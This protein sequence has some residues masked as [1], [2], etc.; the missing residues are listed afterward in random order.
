MKQRISHIV[1]VI[2]ALAIGLVPQVASAGNSSPVY[3]DFNKS[4]V[5]PAGVWQ[6]TVSGDIEG[7]LTT[8]LTDLRVTGPIWHVEFDWI[9]DSEDDN[10]DFTAHLTGVLNTETGG[11]V[12]NGNVV[13]G[14]LLGAQVHEAG[15]LVDPVTLSFEGSIR[16]MPATAP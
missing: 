13:D 6:G 14:Y 9:I 16:I 15:Q 11:V 5:D 4:I 12:M 3:L 8:V 1:M 7:D 2:M 10:Y